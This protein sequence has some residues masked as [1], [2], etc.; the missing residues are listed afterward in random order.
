MKNIVGLNSLRF[1]LAFTVL[2][3]HGALP[4][5]KEVPHL[6]IK[7]TSLFNGVIGNFPVGVAAVMVFFIIS[8]FFIH[9]PYT[10]GKQIIIKE[11]YLKRILRIGIPAV[12]ALA[13][14]NYTNINMSVIWSLI[15]EVIFY[16][17]YPLVL[18]NIKN[19]DQIILF[20]FI[21]SYIVSIL[22]SQ[23]SIIYNGDFHRNGYYITWMVGFP[24][25]LLG[26]K[27]ATRLKLNNIK[28]ITFFQLNLYRI[29][30]CFTASI[31]SVLR[32]HFSISYVFTLPIF[33]LLAFF[34]IEKEI[35]YY[36]GKKEN[37][38]LEYGGLMSYSIY[39]VHGYSFFIV[40]QLSNENT[41]SNNW[42]LCVVVILL[43]LF[44]SWLYYLVIEK[45]SHKFC[46]SL[47]VTN[48]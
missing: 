12:I 34:W 31:C 44:L 20:A 8:G 19:L 26:V 14:Y 21:I 10:N 16:L 24:V 46:R 41:L 9:Y 23:N 35:I 48:S 37:R 33:A 27:L 28:T 38:I 25:W 32:F 18:R 4:K 22:F 5:I 45:P 7:I 40:K 11:F 1:I 29:A 15:C 6:N 17:L 42:I 36:K 13:M 43:S 2:V 47:K 39:L 30:V 3:G